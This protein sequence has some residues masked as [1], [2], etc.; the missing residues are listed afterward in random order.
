MDPAAEVWITGASACTALGHEP[1]GVGRALLAGRSGIRRIDRFPV[2]DH[3]CR[4]GG[5]VD[6][7]PL[8]P[9]EDAA[10]FAALGRLEQL[11]RYCCI[12]ALRD[13]GLWE[14]RRERR[15]GI[16]LGLGAE[17]QLR[18]E[19]ACLA[20]AAP[21][22][23]PDAPPEGIL[24]RTRRHLGL[25][26]PVAAVSAACA[27][28]NVALSQARAWLRLGWCDA[29][30]AGGCDMAVTGMSLAGFGNL[31][32][33]SRR[34]DAPAEASRP[35]DLDRDGFVIGEGGAAFLLE[36]AADARLRGASPQAVVAGYGA[37]SDAFHMVIPN[38]DPGPAAEAVRLALA[39][40]GLNPH[41]VDY[42]NAHATATPV[43][44]ACE[45][46]VLAAALGDHV[47]T[48]PV[49]S[50]KS[51]TGHLVSGAAAIEALACLA[52]IRHGAIPPTINLHRP[53]PA[54]PL[55][56]V[57]HE[58]IPHRVRVAVSNSFGFGGSNACLVL[59][60]A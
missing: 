25:S 59:R 23:Q 6:A 2:H 30:V 45:A 55:R 22:W 50:T 51:M 37:T 11:V 3:P 41:E 39:D 32:A 33:L 29:L 10:G 1:H 9:G 38:P 52:A 14:A 36:R 27:S 24:E 31:R 21:G 13:G 5:Q 8:P 35:F 7:V 40:A 26:G 19:A 60:A 58:A 34:N 47:R 12:Q 18:W 48:V 42:V 49:S 46:R 15:I 56:H 20:H 28:G 54:C 53:D 4:I 43:G 16:V 17:W 57:A 44:D